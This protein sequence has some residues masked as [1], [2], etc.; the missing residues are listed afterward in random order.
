MIGTVRACV[1]PLILAIVAGFGWAQPNASESYDFQ[2]PV[3]DIAAPDD[4]TILVTE[5]VVVQ[6]ITDAGV[7]PV[8][9]VS[10]VEGS[11]VNGL[12]AFDGDGFLLTSGG[13]DLALGA[14]VWRV[15][16]GHASMVTDIEAFEA[17]HDP[18]AMAGRNWKHPSCEDDAAQ[19]F[20]AGPQSNPY[21]LTAISEDTALVADAAGNTLLSTDMVGEVDWVAVF[22]P[23]VDENGEWRFFR[24]A[25]NDPDID[26]YVQPV[27]TSVD[28][29]P[30][31]AYYVGELTGAPAVP[32]WS[33][34]W[35]IES[36]A[37]NA[38][39]PSDVCEVALS[40]LTSVIDVAFG[41]DGLLYVVEMDRA[42]WLSLI[43]GGSL[44]G[45]I[46]RCDVDTGDCE[47]VAESELPLMAVA[48]DPEGRLWVAENEGIGPGVGTVR[49]VDLP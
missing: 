5:G 23:P 40:G 37:M 43:V 41:P 48:F 21:H 36:G 27:P 7:E 12:A 19:G 45:A 35:R 39:C 25:E 31:G 42:G 22:E 13:L 4:G 30:D 34:V 49:T 47:V 24:P 33:R 6:R 26:C 28:V 44:G 32:G 8:V 29:G 3:F 14:G 15:V 38:V 46:K 20:T 1:G 18:D 9:V 16:D 2:G 10:T 17:M 11:P